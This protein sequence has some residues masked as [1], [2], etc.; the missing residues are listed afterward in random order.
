[1]KA[2]YAAHIIKSTSRFLYIYSTTSGATRNTE[3]NYYDFV[4]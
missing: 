1:M 4:D 2:M 3:K